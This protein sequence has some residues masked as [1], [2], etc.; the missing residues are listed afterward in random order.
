MAD[1]HSK[2]K[3][4]AVL[5]RSPNSSERLGSA[6][7][8]IEFARSRH[9]STPTRNTFS[10]NSDRRVTSSI[11]LGDIDS[12]DRKSIKSMR[13]HLVIFMLLEFQS[14]VKKQPLNRIEPKTFAYGQSNQSLSIQ[15]PRYHRV[16]ISTLQPIAMVEPLDF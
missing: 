1:W 9:D 5:K 2:T 8:S 16:D 11:L 6:T 15:P 14:C 7:G 13:R 10:S 12:K 3:E 4:G